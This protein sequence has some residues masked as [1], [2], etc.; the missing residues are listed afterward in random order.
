METRGVSKRKRDQGKK[1]RVVVWKAN[2]KGK[3]VVPIAGIL[4]HGEGLLLGD[5]REE[6]GG[7]LA[8]DECLELI[9]TIDETTQFGDTEFIGI[10]RANNLPMASLLVEFFEK[11]DRLATIDTPKSQGVTALYISCQ[12]GHGELAKLLVD[13]GADINK[14]TTNDGATPLYIACQEGHNGVVKL[15]LANG[16]DANRLAYN[17]NRP[18]Y[19]ACYFGH[20][21]CLEMLLA[22]NADASPH[23]GHCLLELA[24]SRGHLG[25]A[26]IL[27]E[28]P[29]TRNQIAVKLC[30]SALQRIGM[31]DVVNATPTNDL[32]KA[33]FAFK[34]LEEMKSRQMHGLA[35]LVVSYVGVSD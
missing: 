13:K 21:Q 35:D 20:E 26:R 12:E 17:G 32:S 8:V 10:F 31:Y 2:I 7:L 16:A 34:V 33:M 25:C 22:Y 27:R 9:H 4:F 18:L 14:A 15:L 11:N 6:D 28:W 29:V 24:D 1:D 19:A 3:D 5:D 30:V 23:N